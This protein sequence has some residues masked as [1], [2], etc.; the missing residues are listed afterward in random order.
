MAARIARYFRGSISLEFLFGLTLKKL[1]FYYDLYEFEAVRE[2]IID[3]NSVDR[4]GKPKKLPSG[5]VI[6]ELTEE[7]IRRG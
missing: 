4:N 1:E 3:E 2:D 7:R 6:T 5:K